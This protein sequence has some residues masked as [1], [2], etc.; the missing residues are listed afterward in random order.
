MKNIMIT[1]WGLQYSE[2]GNGGDVLSPSG[3]RKQREETLLGLAELK[4][5]L[6]GRSCDTVRR[7]TCPQTLSL[8]DPWPPAGASHGPTSVGG[9]EIREQGCAFH[10]S[11]FLVTE[12]GQEEWRRERGGE[13]RITRIVHQTK[14]RRQAELGVWVIRMDAGDALTG[15][16]SVYRLGLYW[17]PSPGGRS[18]E[19]RR[20]KPQEVFYRKKKKKLP[21]AALVQKINNS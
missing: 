14:P 19:C 6:P 3:S 10:G 4:L 1:G 7:Q 15:L 11:S 13:Q 2:A 17:G 20:T 16:V 8:A 12:Q 5:S 18:C 9:R 21:P